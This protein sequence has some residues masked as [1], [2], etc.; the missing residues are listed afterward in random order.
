MHS[1]HSKI[2]T[3]ENVLGLYQIHVDFQLPKFIVH[4]FCIIHHNIQL[5]EFGYGR[6][7]CFF[8]LR[9]VGHITMAK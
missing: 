3:E 7:E 5:I 8:I 1:A 6:L 2:Q 4:D 9:I